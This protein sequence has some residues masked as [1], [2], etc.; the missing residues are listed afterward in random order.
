MEYLKRIFEHFS[1]IVKRMSVSQVVML[2]AIVAGMI[3]GIV[4]VAGW[5]GKVT[6]QPLY[7]NLDSSEAAQITTYLTDKKIPYQLSAGGTTIKVPESDLYEAR[8]ALAS[9]GLPHSGTVGYSIF[10]ETNLGMTD[11]LQK[12]NFRRALEGELAKTISSLNEV[13]AARVH[14][15]IPE[16]RLFAEQQKEATASVVLKLTHRDGLTKSQISGISHLVASSVEGLKSGN[17]T[18]VDYNGNILSGGNSGSDNIALTSNQLEVTQALEQDL[19]RKAQTMLDGVLGMG[20]SI[21]RV[22]AELDFQEYSRTSENYDPN[23]VAIRS[24]QRT[25]ATDQASK[26]GEENAEDT[27]ENRSEVTVT[28]YEVSKTVEALRNAPGTIK[29]LSVAVTLDG[30]YSM[31]ENSDGVEE[32]VYEPRPQDEIDRL[33]AIVKNV[34]G[35]SA[36]RNDQIEIVNIA[37]DNTYLQDQQKVLDQQYQREFYV[38]IIK[39]VMMW[40]V[41]IL[42]LLYLRKKIKKFFVGL[43]KI[44]PPVSKSRPVKQTVA[45]IQESVPEEEEEEESEIILEKRKPKLIDHMQ[46]AAK[47]EPEE[48]ARV[49]RTMMVD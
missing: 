13:R 45:P 44:L 1:E 20:K 19:E 40:A 4:A 26:K 34:V 23:L 29:R 30:T 15:V 17:I 38:G 32:L 9:Q 49:I 7:A 16:E 31:I 48:I 10:D 14:I 43:G 21:V 36:E 46:K 24:E 37:F 3:V 42:I 2:V 6:Y 8:L 41:G 35:F 25:E 39:Q 22:S 12:L 5:L 18:I 27:Q 33:S 47:D 28:N 11:F